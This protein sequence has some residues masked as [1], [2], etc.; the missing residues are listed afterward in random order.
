M[1]GILVG[2][3]FIALPVLMEGYWIRVFTSIFMYAIITAALNIIA[4]YTGYAAFGNIVFFGVGAYTTAMLMLR[5]GFYWVT[6]LPLL[7]WELI[8]QLNRLHSTGETSQE[9]EKELHCLCPK[10]RSRTFMP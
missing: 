3:G 1:I 2:L 10:W 4:G 9:E 8:G 5:I 7:P 6:I